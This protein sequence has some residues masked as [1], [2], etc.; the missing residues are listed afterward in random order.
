[1]QKMILFLV[2]IVMLII[3]ISMLVYSDGESRKATDKEKIFYKN[4]MDAIYSSIPPAPEGWNEIKAK[5]S[6]L[7]LVGKDSE[8]YPF[9]IDYN[10]TWNDYKRNRAAE[11]ELQKALIPIISNPDRMNALQQLSRE[12]DSLIKA[13]G[14]AVGK[15]DKRT[16]ERLGK[17]LESQQIKGKELYDQQDREVDRA[18]E[19][20]SPHD[21]SVMFRISIN[22]FSMGIDESTVQDQNVAG[23]PAYRT[24]GV[25]E[26]KIGWR[27]GTT[28]VLIGKGWQMKTDAGKYF[29]TKPQPNVSSTTVQTIVVSVQADSSRAKEILQ[30]IDW[31]TLKKLMN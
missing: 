23:C 11:D 3:P 31:N 9:R 24:K 30:K 20:M 2:M 21:V 17:E 29:E 10:V 19:K 28:Y 1:M 7:E 13:F 16:T 4:V 25:W 15:N 27:E 5:P 8:K 26:K 22:N 14:E 12:N 18:M 6:D